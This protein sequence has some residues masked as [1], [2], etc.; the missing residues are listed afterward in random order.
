M[1]IRRRLLVFGWT[2]GVL[3]VV[4]GPYVAFLLTGHSIPAAGW[5]GLGILAALVVGSG[6]LRR[7]SSDHKPN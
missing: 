4:L 2:A 7:I 5:F 3:T 6:V 1:N